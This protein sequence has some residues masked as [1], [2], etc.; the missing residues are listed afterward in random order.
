MLLM[1]I[2]EQVSK[3]KILKFKK[4]TVRR[5]DYNSKVNTATFFLVKQQ[6]I[7]GYFFIKKINLKEK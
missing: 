7:L 5:L 4:L 6:F 1:T 3:Q 2:K